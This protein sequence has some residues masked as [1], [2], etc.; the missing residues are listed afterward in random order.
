[1]RRNIKKGGR[2]RSQRAGTKNGAGDGRVGEAGRREERE[3][4]TNPGY[5]VKTHVNC[6]AYSRL[7]TSV[8]LPLPSF[9]S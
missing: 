3:R 6:L 9:L 8:F 5:Q 4:H 1:M 7:T 2:E